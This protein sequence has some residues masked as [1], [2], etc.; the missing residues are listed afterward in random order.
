MPPS[1]AERKSQFLA[2]VD[3]IFGPAT[4]KAANLI[5]RPVNMKEQI[6]TKQPYI[7]GCLCA[8]TALSS[9]ASGA[10]KIRRKSFQILHVIG[11]ETS[12]EY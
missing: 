11:T 4:S 7:W 10:A 9:L 12:V 6:W 2:H 1:A 5:P 3:V 8:V